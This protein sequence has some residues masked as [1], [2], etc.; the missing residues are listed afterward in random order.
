MPWFC[1]DIRD[2]KSVS[3]ER[4]RWFWVGRRHKGK[5]VPGNNWVGD[6][7]GLEFVALRLG[8]F[9][10]IS[11]KIVGLDEFVPHAMALRDGLDVSGVGEVWSIDCQRDLPSGLRAKDISL[12]EGRLAH[13]LVL[14]HAVL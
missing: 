4:T 9:N 1:G 12:L 2:V 11:P 13:L 7:I 10:I 8:F 14:M 6:S 3:E 5:F